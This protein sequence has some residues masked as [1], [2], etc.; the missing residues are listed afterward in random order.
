MIVKQLQVEN[1]RN[2]QRVEIA[3]HPTI[4]ILFGANGAGKTSVLEAIAVLSRGRSFRGNR[5]GQL[6]GPYKETLTVFAEIS[7]EQRSGDG[8]ASL[9]RLGLERGA[10]AWKARRDGEDLQQ[11][12]ELAE[13][14]AVVVM[15]PN[16]H[17]LISGSPEIR[18][19][20]LDWGVFHVEPPYLKA[21]QRYARALR[22]R[23]AAL[24]AGERSV[25]PS[26]ESVLVAAGE[27]MST[28]RAAYSEQLSAHL[29][30]LIPQLSP[31]LGKVSVDY[32]RGWAGDG[33]QP[34]L[35][36]HREKDLERG[37]TQC[38]PHRADLA[39]RVEGHSVRDS[40]SRG[41]EK[42]L[43]T[44][45]VLAQARRQC[46]TGRIPVLLLDDLASEFDRDHF[47]AALQ[48]GMSLGVQMWITGVEKFDP[49][50][51]HSRFHVERGEVRKVV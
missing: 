17:E 13:S 19:R 28:M 50:S 6:I 35:E 31:E 15:E 4:N 12:S 27:A 8:R 51:P 2:L 22:Q 46:E 40:V 42:V 25:L 3:A 29:D 7:D 14:L 44:A 48:M 24:R 47:A 20:Y 21:W 18:R 49:G 36:S 37:S 30:S 11:L 5:I 38:G 9:T 43:A 23:N 41:E 45:L 39:I 32:R 16:S 10:K 34:A 26:L 33:L 1:L